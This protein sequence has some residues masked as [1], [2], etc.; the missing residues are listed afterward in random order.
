MVPL[1][2]ARRMLWFNA[3]FGR[4][5][6]GPVSAVK[7]FLWALVAFAVIVILFFGTLSILQKSSG[8]IAFADEA[9]SLMTALADYHREFGV[10]P[11]LAPPDSLAIE[12][13]KVLVKAGHAPK[14]PDLQDADARYVSF[15]GK[16]YGL[17]FHLGPSYLNRAV[18][19]CLIEVDT[20]N[21]MW[22][23]ESRK[24]PL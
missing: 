4:D 2:N 19:S 6:G 24:C 20:A 23:G 14:K 5:S 13:K 11:V 12:V 8:R 9:Q 1:I 15:D 7:D 18:H 10:Y 21:N 17:L 22:W 3:A 16:S